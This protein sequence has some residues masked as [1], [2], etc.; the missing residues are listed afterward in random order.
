MAMENIRLTPFEIGAICESFRAYFEPED[1]L[2]LFGSRVNPKARGGDIDLYIETTISDV[3]TA[4]DKNTAFVIDLYDK[5][6]EQK[7]DVV[8]NLLTRDYKL[9]IYEVAREEGVQLV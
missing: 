4:V 3:S 5:I 8:L 6:G 7:I 2:W 9:A 1:H